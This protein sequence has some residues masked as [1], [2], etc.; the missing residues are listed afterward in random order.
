MANKLSTIWKYLTTSQGTHIEYKQETV[1]WDG[2]SSKD[3]V[4][5]IKEEVANTPPLYQAIGLA[6]V[7]GI[8]TFLG[9]GVK[10]SVE[11]IVHTEK[12]K[13]EWIY[14][15]VTEL[16]HLQWK[17]EFAQ[18]RMR[19]DPGSR[20]YDSFVRDAA[21]YSGKLEREKD[22][23]RAEVRQ[24]LQAGDKIRTGYT[25]SRLETHFG[26]EGWWEER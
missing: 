5:T 24:K 3:S 8:A 20:I 23:V 19:Q 15:Y 26:D 16:D 22:R 17:L 2:H 4:E 7:I 9:W 13:K 21:E 6:L 18:E 10:A 14:P 25:H 1:G 11:R 12:D